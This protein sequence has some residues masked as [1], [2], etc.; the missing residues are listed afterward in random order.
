MKEQLNLFE[1]LSDALKEKKITLQES[2]IKKLVIYLELLNQW[3]VVHNLTAIRD[4]KEMVSK[5]ILDSLTLLPLLTSNKHSEYVL[6]I[7][8]VGTGAGLPGIPLSL[9][10]P[11]HQ[12]VLLDKNQ[13]KI[14]FIQ[15]V[16]LSLNLKNVL[17]SRHRVEE[18]HP[19]ILFDWILSRAFASLS[20][21]VLMTAHLAKGEGRWLAMKGKSSSE[22]LAALPKGYTIEQMVNLSVNDAKRTLIVIKKM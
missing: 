12:F 3:N 15:H 10:M 18:Y 16:I 19:E 21:F 7:L 22:E 14:N 5:H 20:D 2:I 1:C 6:R 13:K 9:C 8:D 11:Q 17:A 4:P